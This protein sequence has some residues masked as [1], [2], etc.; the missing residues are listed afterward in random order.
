MKTVILAL[1]MLVGGTAVAQQQQ[2]S[3]QRTAEER[4]TASAQRMATRFGLD[5]AQR[6]KIYNINLGIAQQNDVIRNNKSLT[7][8]QRTTQLQET[9]SSLSAQY[10]GVLTNDQYIKYEAWDKE[11]REKMQSK[12][13][14]K[15]NTQG[16]PTSPTID[17]DDL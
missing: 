5:E 4:A 11:R 12:R 6:T 3:A 2:K 10:K 13:N 7:D 8:E 15:Q 16:S 1:A 14:Q 17:E 9:H